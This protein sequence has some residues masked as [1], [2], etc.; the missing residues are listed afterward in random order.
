MS[1]KFDLSVEEQQWL[2][3]VMEGG[4]LAPIPVETAEVL[5]SKGLVT[6]AE[7]VLSL[8][9]AGL[10]EAKRIAAVEFQFNTPPPASA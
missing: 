8:T 10:E 7:G 2:L 6:E 4:S 9:Q 1:R 5:S 3:I